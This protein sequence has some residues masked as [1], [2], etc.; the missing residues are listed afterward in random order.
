MHVLG[1]NGYRFV[2]GR[3][4]VILKVELDLW[5]VCLLHRCRYQSER[6]RIRR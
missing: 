4:G 6:L 2:P 1:G 5:V 3:V